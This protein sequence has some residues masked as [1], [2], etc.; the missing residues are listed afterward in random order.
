MWRID[1]DMVA[2]TYLPA[3]LPVRVHHRH[4]VHR[5]S[6]SDYR[7]AVSAEL[8]VGIGSK[9]TL[10]SFAQQD[11]S[12]ASQLGLSFPWLIVSRSPGSTPRPTRYSFVAI[13]LL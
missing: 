1:E 6:G 7:P 11:S 9:S 5:L 13:A 4:K 10:L 8:G 3:L 2:K 12:F